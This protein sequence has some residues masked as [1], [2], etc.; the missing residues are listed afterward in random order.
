MLLV[1]P[2]QGLDSDQA[3]D[4]LLEAWE[5][6]LGDVPDDLFLAAASDY[7]R[8]DAAFRPAPG[9]LRSLAMRIS[10]G[11]ADAKALAAWEAV[12]DSDFGRDLAGVDDTAR[13]V[14]QEIGGFEG[15]GN[16]KPED[17]HYWMERFVKLY[18]IYTRRQDGRAL[19]GSG[20]AKTLRLV[21]KR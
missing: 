10:D 20:A 14:M 19:I 17:T 13:K 18:A 16:I 15:F 8:S 2:S 12:Q 5:A 1:Y 7:L 11:D 3:Q 21:G 6:V 9:Q 4:D